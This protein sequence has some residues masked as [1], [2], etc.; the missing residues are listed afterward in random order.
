MRRAE[1]RERKKNAAENPAA[2]YLVAANPKN[3]E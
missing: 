3:P 1:A 2:E